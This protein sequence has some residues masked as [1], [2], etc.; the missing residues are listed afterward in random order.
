MSLSG[1]LRCDTRNNTLF[2][3][4]RPE[5]IAKLVAER[6][7]STDLT[8]TTKLKLL[9]IDAATELQS[10]TYTGDRLAASSTVFEAPLQHGKNKVVLVDG[11]LDAL[12]SLFASEANVRTNVNTKMG[13]LI[14]KLCG[15]D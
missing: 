8:P 12:K 7:G 6:A 2:Y 9:N 11:M 3:N 4:A 1:E 14:G 10:T 5:F 15:G 13:F